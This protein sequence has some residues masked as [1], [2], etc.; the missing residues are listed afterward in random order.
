MKRNSTLWLAAAA[1]LVCFAVIVTLGLR[2]VSAQQQARSRRLL[3][4]TSDATVTHENGQIVIHL[5]RE[6]QQ[7][8]GLA[9]APL[10]SARRARQMAFPAT[11]LAVN[12]L[13]TL[14]SAY[15]S[16]SAQLQ[17]SEISATVSRQ[18]YRRLKKLY[19][20]QQNVSAKA[21]QAA[22]GVY[23][24][25][26]VDVRLAKEHLS[27][28][29][30]AVRQNWGSTIAGWVVHDTSSVQSILDHAD[31]LIEMTLPVGET[32][33]AP[34]EFEFDLPAGGHASA[35][36][37][38]A[39]PQVDPRVQGVGYLYI[40]PSR[41]GL[42]PGLNLVAQFG[43]G[44]LRKGVIVPG[45]AVVWLHGKAWVYIATGEGRFVRHG[46]ATKIP[47]SGGWF[48]AKGFQPGDSVVTQDAQQILAVELAAKQ[49]SHGEIRGDQD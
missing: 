14:V 32:L 37:V 10:Q 8:L 24:S 33:S 38:S 48:M 30:G 42:A 22:K 15:Q 17:K 3:A 2:A 41:P 20:E 46:V 45:G 5:S 34:S 6:A 23:Q 9:E 13:Q 31:V 7:N 40:T 1:A 47:A 11:V 49:P 36:R 28:A 44:A 18:E 12:N 21:V 35:H 19:G 43:V 26:E 16:A 39:F 29:S 25:N 27:I 4:A